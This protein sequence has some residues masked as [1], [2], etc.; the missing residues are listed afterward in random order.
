LT[1]AIGC[2]EY[3]GQNFSMALARRSEDPPAAKGT[4]AVIGFDGNTS[5]AIEAAGNVINANI[6]AAITATNLFIFLLLSGGCPEPLP[7]RHGGLTY[8]ENREQPD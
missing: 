6:T 7:Q 4:T 5:A 2:F 3:F 1:T 8:R